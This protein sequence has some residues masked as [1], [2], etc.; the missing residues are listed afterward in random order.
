MHG[1]FRIGSPIGFFPAADTQFYMYFC[2][3]DLDENKINLNK[4]EFTECK[5]VGIEEALEMFQNNE[6]PIFHP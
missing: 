1:F 3:Y 2:D 6:I 5:W 4:S